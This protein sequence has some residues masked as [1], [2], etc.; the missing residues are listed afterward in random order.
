MPDPGPIEQIVLR[1]ASVGVRGAD[2]LCLMIKG[3]CA[4]A[5]DVWLLPL[6]EVSMDGGSGGGPSEATRCSAGC[7]EVGYPSHI[8]LLPSQ[9]PSKLQVLERPCVWVPAPL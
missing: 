8:L 7:L 1:P 9:D 4:C 2:P 6:L 5:L 3:R